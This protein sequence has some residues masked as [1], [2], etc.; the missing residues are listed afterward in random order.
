MTM[1][2]EALKESREA[3]D[4]AEIKARILE[5][6]EREARLASP[7]SRSEMA[8]HE[9]HSGQLVE[10]IMERCVSVAEASAELGIST[11]RLY[12]LIKLGKVQ[13]CRVGKTWIIVRPLPA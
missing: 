11:Q 9:V 12:K 5:A 3:E 4:L 13:A 8:E 10:Q 1:N 7:R 2:K 6:R